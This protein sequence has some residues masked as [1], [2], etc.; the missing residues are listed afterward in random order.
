[1]LRSL[2]ENPT[3]LWVAVDFLTRGVGFSHHRLRVVAMRRQD[4]RRVECMAQREQVLEEMQ[5]IIEAGRAHVRRA[6]RVIAQV[7]ELLARAA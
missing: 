5:R 3:R 1:M 6:R 7:D 2:A 4:D